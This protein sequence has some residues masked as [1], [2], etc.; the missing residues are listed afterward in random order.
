MRTQ[1]FMVPVKCVIFS[2]TEATKSYVRLTSRTKCEAELS[3]RP[4]ENFVP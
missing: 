1:L 4:R 3:F 2:T